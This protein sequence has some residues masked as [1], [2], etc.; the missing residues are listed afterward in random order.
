METKSLNLTSILDNE[1]SHYRDAYLVNVGVM[2]AA[3][4]IV[5]FDSTDSLCDFIGSHPELTFSVVGVP[6]Y[7]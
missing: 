4:T 5:V 7:E 2:G 3:P 6:V 1:C